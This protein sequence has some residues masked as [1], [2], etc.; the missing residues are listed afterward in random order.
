M[1]ITWG[2]QFNER[3]FRRRCTFGASKADDFEYLTNLI[4]DMDM[5]TWCSLPCLSTSR[6]INDF[7]PEQGLR[8]RRAGGRTQGPGKR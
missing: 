1:L 7:R 2:S 5:V 8:C 6:E 4:F 3:R